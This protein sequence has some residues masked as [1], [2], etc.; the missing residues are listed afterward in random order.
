MV[1]AGGTAT[2][3][4]YEFAGFRLDTVT[5][6]FESGGQ[7]IHLEP[8]M[9][10]ALLML[11][12]RPGE[13]I[14]QDE[15][16]EKI[17]LRRDTSE[18]SLATLIGKLRKVIGKDLVATVHRAGYRLT[19]PVH[20]HAASSVGPR[21]ELRAGECLEERPHWQLV[22]RLG[23]GGSADAWLVRHAKTGEERVFKLA[24]DA[25]G[26]TALK[27]EVTIARLLQALPDAGLNFRRIIDWQSSEPP[28]FVEMPHYEQNL[29]EWMADEVRD[30][31]SCLAIVTQLAAA[32]GHAHEIGVL[33]KDLKP[34]NIFV[35]RS[36]D[37][38]HAVLGDFGCGSLL[39]P[40][41]LEPFGISR[42]GFSALAI[43][44]DPA[45]GTVFYIAPEVLAG[46]APT[47]RADLYAL[48]VLLY[49]LLAGDLRRPLPADWAEHIDDVL[50]REDVAL[51][52][53]SDPQRR[54]GSGAEF[55]QRL[56]ALEFRR[57]EH[58]RRLCEAAEMQLAR[59]ALDRARARRPWMLAAVGLLVLG[60]AISLQLLRQTRVQRAQA[61][62]QLAV[63]TA[64]NSLLRDGIVRAG[65]PFY[66]GRPSLPLNEAV[67]RGVEQLGGLL[68]GNSAVE[69]ELRASM[70]GLFAA[71]TDF[72]EAEK[73]WRRRLQLLEVQGDG[74]SPAALDAR[75][76]LAEMLLNQG[77]WD[78]ARTYSQAVTAG[79]AAAGGQ[80]VE[81][82]YRAVFI[83]AFIDYESG[84]WSQTERTLSTLFA[85]SGNQ[86]IDAVL[87]IRARQLYANVLV[88]L[89]RREEALR[90]VDVTVQ[91]AEA[92][93]GRD[94]IRYLY[95]RMLRAV[96]LRQLDRIADAEREMLDLLQL[97]TDRLGDRHKETLTLRQELAVLYADSGRPQQAVPLLE[98]A[99][100]KRLEVLGPGHRQTLSALG[101]LSVVLGR[102]GRK[103]EALE[104]KHQVY[105]QTRISL[106]S[107]HPETLIAGYNLVEAQ[108][109]SSRPADAERGLQQLRD[110][111]KE[112]L[113]DEHQWR[114]R[115]LYLDGRLAEQRGERRRAKQHWEQAY[116]L[117]LP[118]LPDSDG[119][120]VDLRH[121]LGVAVAN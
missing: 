103:R 52:T 120:L 68:T 56:R 101:D 7:R 94:N 40:E 100:H 34:D 5:M 107:A 35:E 96:C 25:A 74:D 102:L 41:A 67:K 117:L 89:D 108:L 70:G 111:G 14:T 38:W 57:L 11:L 86:P 121:R 13:V 21:L 93:L 79:L 60:L 95:A 69:S 36:G 28:F 80:T 112:V 16:F 59:E 44:D 104:L 106:G 24:G 90:F 97:A 8:K 50:L 17:W 81:I 6:V 78:E 64:L 54:I 77:R 53:A 32:L 2:A 115:L 76:W 83:A 114:A 84:H 109:D 19:V 33:H 22:R 92:R 46:Q 39:N 43:D 110:D 73:H 119:L 3:M 4:R 30:V 63:A 118:L 61:D 55:A 20:R 71:L 62:K 42:L 26:L 87:E 105:E 75:M 47:A 116:S 49:Q 31:A 99:Y 45:A 1:Q 29:R 58:E 48:G 51:A 37:G 27:R 12:E 91:M 72:P 23:S 88:A 10:D 85:D 18:H 66:G 98:D 82:R 113:A 65:D 15:F 9:R